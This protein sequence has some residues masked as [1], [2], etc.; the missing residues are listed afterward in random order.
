[1]QK[2][3]SIDPS[4]TA[5]AVVAA[6]RR[7][8]KIEFIAY[9]ECSFSKRKCNWV[10]AYK[11]AIQCLEAVIQTSGF[12]TDVPVL[13]E[14]WAFA[15]NARTA[16]AL[17][18]AQQVWICAASQLGHDVYTMKVTTWQKYVG[19]TKVKN[20][21]EEKN[22]KKEF[23]RDWVLKSYGIDDSITFDVSDALAMAHAAISGEKLEP[24]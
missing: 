9:E 13:I 21:K 16:V 22:K 17:A 15:R 23:V 10:D 14:S 3:I 18:R 24:I 7:Y 6:E 8:E 19:A 20:S 5:S 2:I 11:R 1:M 4:K 12:G